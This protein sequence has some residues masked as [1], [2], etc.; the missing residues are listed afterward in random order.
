M[1]VKFWGRLIFL[2]NKLIILIYLGDNKVKKEIKE[3]S[4]EEEIVNEFVLKFG[5]RK[6]FCLYFEGFMYYGLEL[7]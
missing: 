7:K 4:G 6:E 3:F 5:I 1:L 2:G